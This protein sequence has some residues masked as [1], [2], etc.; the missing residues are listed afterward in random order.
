MLVLNDENIKVTSK[1]I[2]GVMINP[3]TEMSRI[4]SKPRVEA[5]RPGVKEKPAPIKNLVIELPQDYAF[6]SYKAYHEMKMN[7]KPDE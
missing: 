2:S 4:M 1:S 3:E 5:S 7:L 6:E